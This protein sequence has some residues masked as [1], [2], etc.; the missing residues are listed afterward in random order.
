[1]CRRLRCE[2]GMIRPPS[3]SPAGHRAR[4][5]EAEPGVADDEGTLYPV[6][7]PN[8]FSVFRKP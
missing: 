3:S 8:I 7:E 4:L 1:M 5:L 6:S 2:E